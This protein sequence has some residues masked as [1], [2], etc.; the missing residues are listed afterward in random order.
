MTWKWK[1]IDWLSPVAPSHV[2]L[3]WFRTHFFLFSSFILLV[4][5]LSIVRCVKHDDTNSYRW[6]QV[7]HSRTH[8][9][10]SKNCFVSNEGGS[11][12]MRSNKIGKC[13]CVFVWWMMFVQCCC[14][15]QSFYAK[16]GFVQEKESTN[17]HQNFKAFNFDYYLLIDFFLLFFFISLKICFRNDVHWK[18][19]TPQYW[20]NHYISSDGQ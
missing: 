15:Y 11:N 8:F 5:P 18:L 6:L 17:C 20:E 10:K 13:M 14:C 1:D 7:T 9:G 2:I 19:E 16:Y 12:I 4:F 3:M